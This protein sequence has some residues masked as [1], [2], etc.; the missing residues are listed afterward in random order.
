MVEACIYTRLS[1][2]PDGSTE[3]VERQEADA[4]QVAARLG[5]TVGEV[6]VDNSRSAWR[7]DVI[8]KDWERMLLDLRGGRWDAVVVYH[9]D[10]LVRQP[11]DL[12]RLLTIADER[13]LALASVSGTRDLSSPDDRF[14]LRIEAAQACRESD[15]IS[16]RTRR[17]NLAAAKKGLPRQGRRR[18]YG[19][20]ADGTGLIPAEAAELRAW[21]RTLLAGG[22][23][24]GLVRDLRDR[25]VPA[26]SG[27]AWTETTVRDMLLNPRIAGLACYRG[28]I[29]GPSARPAVLP[30]DTWRALTAVFSQRAAGPG[31]RSRR[32]LLS[33][34]ALCGSCGG[35][36]YAQMQGREEHGRHVY[37]CRNDGCP[38]PKVARDQRQLDRYVVSV[39]IGMLAAIQ[40]GT[41]GDPAAELKLDLAGLTRRLEELEAEFSAAT[42]RAASMLIRATSDLERQADA[43]RARIAATGHRPSRAAGP[44]SQAQWDALPLDRRRS[45]VADLLT[46]TV[47]PSGGGR[48]GFRPDRVR[49]TPL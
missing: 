31:S 21:T 45:I 14:I 44:V 9:G 15:N 12:E 5:W 16:R 8:R 2:A 3:K 23:L 4:R 18:A 7:R 34:L 39:A 48:G 36:L 35:A 11:H 40:P 19:W 26:A 29:V 6:Y 28:E 24:T 42:G 17:G 13:H 25:Q 10:R 43:V 22:S 32:F 37:L 1:D 46:V 41:P 47:L 30:E 49:I 33:G 38:G 27:G 20:T